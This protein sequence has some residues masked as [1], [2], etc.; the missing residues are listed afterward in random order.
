MSSEYSD[1][2]DPSSSAIHTP[3][4]SSS[5]SSSK[6]SS[7]HLSADS[8]TPSA[9]RA[10]ESAQAL[11]TLA[12]KPTSTQMASSSH[13][14]RDSSSED[15]PGADTLIVH[16][17]D[18]GS[19]ILGPL[20]TKP[21][22]FSHITE[23]FILP[24]GFSLPIIV[25]GFSISFR[26]KELCGWPKPT[27]EYEEWLDRVSEQWKNELKHWGIY[28][29]IVFSKL[30]FS[31]ILICSWLSWVFRIWLSMPLFSHLGSCLLPYLMWP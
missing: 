7:I 11:K 19:Y 22:L 15:E 31:Q 3:S 10:Q 9:D 8:Q 23:S 29:M 17:V 6:S 1:S 14:A 25:D 5:S 18:H 26:P 4:K 20:C 12:S 16:D 28:D 30:N 27:P 13:P 24:D 21:P 2:E